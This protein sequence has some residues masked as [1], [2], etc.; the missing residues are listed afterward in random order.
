MEQEDV[1]R[2]L[3]VFYALVQVYL[4]YKGMENKSRLRSNL[5]AEL[6]FKCPCG[7]QNR[8]GVKRSRQSLRSSQSWY[9]DKIKWSKKMSEDIFLFL[10]LGASLFAACV[11]ANTGTPT[12]KREQQSFYSAVF[13]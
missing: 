9:P 12:R 8:K 2:H 7:K 4:Q 11:V 6:G 5:L 1:G 13:V 10:C 3:F